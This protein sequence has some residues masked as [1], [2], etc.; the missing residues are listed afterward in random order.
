MLGVVFTFFSIKSFAGEKL[1]SDIG[2][3]LYMYSVVT[4]GCQK[5]PKITGVVKATKAKSI[6]NNK[7]KENVMTFWRQS[8]E[9]QACGHARKTTLYFFV[10]GNEKK[11]Y[12]S[13]KSK[14][15]AIP[16]ARTKFSGTFTS[17]LLKRDTFGDVVRFLYSK[18]CSVSKND[19]MNRAKYYVSSVVKPID[20]VSNG[21]TKR[22]LQWDEIW[23]IDACGSNYLFPIVFTGDGVGGTF[24]RI[25][26]VKSKKIE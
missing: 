21:K 16:M 5:I 13:I 25:G 26:K 6:Q 12:Y 2:R 4:N 7:T 9:Y 15:D 22:V 11:V 24:W 1:P 18:K 17:E 19:L 20:V 23:S 8:I 10:Y 14:S 3:S